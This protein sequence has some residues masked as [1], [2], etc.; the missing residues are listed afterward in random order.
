MDT[1]LKRIRRILVTLILAA[2]FLLLPPPFPSGA[3][4]LDARPSRPITA[5]PARAVADV[6]GPVLIAGMDLHDGHVR[7]IG[8]L[9]YFYGQQ[10]TCA[11][12]SFQWYGA[13]GTSTWCGYA[14]S[15]ASS[16]TGPWSAPKRLFDPA[17][18]DPFLGATFQE[19]CAGGSSMGCHNPRMIQRTGWGANDGR[20]ILWFNAVR[21]VADGLPNAFVSMGCAGPEGPCGPGVTGGSINKPALD[22]T[23]NGDFGVLERAGSYPAIVCSAPGATQLNLQE[24]NWNGTGGQSGDSVIKVAGMSGPLEGPGGWWDS[25]RSKWVLTASRACGYGGGCGAVYAE[26]PALLSGWSSPGNTGWGEDVLARA[27]FSA[28]SCGGQPRTV[29]VLNGVPY[30][31]I[32]LW[33]APNGRESRNQTDADTLLTPLTYAPQPGVPGDGQVWVPPVSMTCR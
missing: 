9:Y 16:L 14:V 8:E 17:L 19:T 4:T 15:K 1:A 10:Y 13:P 18:A 23:C 29:S 6:T 12:G 7:K 24:L 26:S 25:A 11:E 20:F 22:F 30:Q 28:S 27:T 32:D 31:G 5:G 2:A 3:T 33:V 21:H